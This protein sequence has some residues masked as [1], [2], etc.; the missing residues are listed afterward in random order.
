VKDDLS[1][2]KWR[3][4]S[5]IDDRS[6]VDFAGKTASR[7]RPDEMTLQYTAAPHRKG[8]LENKFHEKPSRWRKHADLPRDRNFDPDRAGGHWN[9]HALHLQPRHRDERVSRGNGSNDDRET[10]GVVRLKGRRAAAESQSESGKTFEIERILRSRTRSLR[11][12]KPACGDRN[13]SPPDAAGSASAAGIA[14]LAPAF[15]Q[16][17]PSLAEVR[18]E[19]S[20]EVNAEMVCELCAALVSEGMG[21]GETWNQSGGSPL[22]FAQHAMMS[23]IGAERGDRACKHR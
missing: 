13:A 11:G 7:S 8:R 9:R 2:R 18:A 23:G 12:H 3:L 19:Y 21:T 20:H 4:L 16:A 14:T 5:L 17:L 6:H 15:G 10:G 22:A 1:R